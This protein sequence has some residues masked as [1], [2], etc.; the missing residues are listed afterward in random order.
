[1]KIP[2]WIASGP[3]SDWHTAI[4]SRICLARDAHVVAIHPISHE[5]YFP[6]KDVGGKPVLRI[7]RGVKE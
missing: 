7:M 2:T 6:L 1:M 5:I 4:A 3:G